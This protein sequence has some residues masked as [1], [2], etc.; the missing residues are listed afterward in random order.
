M[1]RRVLD[2]LACLLVTVAAASCV[3]NKAY[4]TCLGAP[5]GQQCSKPSVLDEK[6]KTKEFDRELSTCTG[7]PPDCVSDVEWPYQLTFV[8][9][10]DRGEMFDRRQLAAAVDT[11]TRAK[12]TAPAGTQ[13]VVAVFIHGWKNNASESSG[14]VWGFRQILAG[15]SLEYKV[16]G[17]PHSPIVGVYIGWRGAVVSAP[18]LKEFTFF[19]RRAKSQNL[20]GPHMGEALVKI[21]QAA[22]GRNFDEPTLSVLIG[23]SFG[24]AVLETALSETIATLVTE[25]QSTRTPIRWPADLIMFLN[26][27]QEATR[28]YQLIESLIANVTEREKCLPKGVE[29]TMQAPAIIS[30][31]STGDSATRVAFPAAQSLARPFNSLRKYPEG[32]NAVGIGSQTSMFFRTTAHMAEFQSHLVRRY[33]PGDLENMGGACKPT[34]LFTLTG[35]PSAGDDE[36]GYVLI[37]KPGSK[38]RTPYWVFRVPPE[39]VPDHSTIFTPVFR[40][41]LVTLIRSRDQMKPHNTVVSPHAP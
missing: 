24:G 37:E 18:L 4:R 10:D 11:I 3:G 22:K 2:L 40:S 29:Q 16:S 17:G 30:V 6:L 9:F 36:P 33:D 38:N 13:P 41:F 21:M 39:V 26:E 1:T 8:E 23:H 7:P 20:P 28:S 32:G 14:N 5:A 27:A 19:D 31:S 25:A 12:A 35:K 34:L 15:L